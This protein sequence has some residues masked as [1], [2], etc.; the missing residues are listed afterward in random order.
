L[1]WALDFGDGIRR[2]PTQLY[3]IIV[4]D[5][6]AAGLHS[7]WLNRNLQQGELWKIFVLAYL[8]FRFCVEFIKPVAHV[9]CG[10]DIEQVVT[11]GA[12]IYYARPT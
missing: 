5:H 9:Y 1:P 3:E 2:H 11:I 4:F 10:L 6:S 7:D 8:S 12:Y